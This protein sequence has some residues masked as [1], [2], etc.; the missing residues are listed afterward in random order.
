MKIDRC[1]RESRTA[2]K[3]PIVA[4][5]V[6]RYYGLQCGIERVEEIVTHAA[7]AHEPQSSAFMLNRLEFWAVPQ[8]VVT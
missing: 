8:H 1:D 5:S 4:V 7:T 3:E 6:E 2:R